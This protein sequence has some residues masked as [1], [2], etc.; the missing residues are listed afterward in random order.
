MLTKRKSPTDAGTAPAT[1][2]APAPPEVIAVD[3]AAL[4]L[5]DLRAIRSIIEAMASGA[6]DSLARR[7]RMAAPA[8]ELID[9]LLK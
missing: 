4:P 6:G 9:S 7:E 8:L 5:G 2:D 3:Y 1:G